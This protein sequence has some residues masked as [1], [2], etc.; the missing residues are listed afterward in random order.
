M[1]KIFGYC[2]VCGEYSYRLVGMTHGD[3]QKDTD[4][5]PVWLLTNIYDMTQTEQDNAII[6]NCGCND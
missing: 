5:T 3:G 4:E 1:E 2:K 6:I